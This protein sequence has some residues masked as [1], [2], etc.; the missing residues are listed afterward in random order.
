M[1]TAGWYEKCFKYYF[2]TLLL[3]EYLRKMVTHELSV[4]L[5]PIYW[6]LLWE[7]NSYTDITESKQ[8]SMRV[9]KGIF[10]TRDRPFFFPVKCEM[11]NFFLVNRDFHS[12]CEAWF[13]KI[14]FH[15]TRNKCLHVIRR[16]PWFSLCL[17]YCLCYCLCSFRDV[18]VDPCCDNVDNVV[19]FSVT[20]ASNHFHSLFR[21]FRP[22]WRK[23]IKSI[24]SMSKMTKMWLC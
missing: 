19:G 3:Q 10:V 13:C 8:S 4:M 24:T 20:L 17:C 16:E 9:V 12:S 5:K 2:R 18:K 11:A 15:E 14:I 7:T 21:L 22:E 6:Q 23:R 1:V